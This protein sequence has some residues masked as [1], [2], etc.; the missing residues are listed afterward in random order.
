VSPASDATTGFSIPFA[1]A[2]ATT[3]AVSSAKTIGGVTIV[4]Q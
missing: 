2:S 1:F 3:R 4:C